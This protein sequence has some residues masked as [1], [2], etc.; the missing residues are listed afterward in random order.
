MHIVHLITSLKIGG[1]ETALYRLL[2]HAEMREHS[3]TILYLYDGPLRDSIEKLGYK[4]KKLSGFFC[5]YDPTLFLTTYFFIR[6]LKPDLVHT[7][8]WS[9]NILGRFVG[10]FL[11]LPV[12]SD[13]HGR[14][15]SEGALRIISEKLTGRFSGALVAVG[16][17]VAR[18]YASLCKKEPF[19]IQNGID[20]LDCREKASIQSLTKELLFFR[21]CFVIGSVGRLEP[22]KGCDRLLRAFALVLKKMAGRITCTLKLC[23]VGDGSQRLFLENLAVELG[24]KESVFFAG[25]QKNALAWYK[26][27]DCFV[28]S[29][30]S[31][32]LS[33]ALLEALAFGVPVITTHTAPT[34][35]VIV[36]GVHG[37]LVQEMTDHALAHALSI[38][39]T[40]DHDA[41]TLMK[42][43]CRERALAYDFSKT[44]Q[45]YLSLYKK[46]IKKNI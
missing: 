26:L 7:A 43:A 46:I 35:D 33:L 3:H 34:H 30:F 29:S 1:A 17:D 14:L 39:L 4:T 2:A 24:I 32:G 36:H 16:Y 28:L 45:G 41:R 44:A 42:K 21:D 38:F 10:L 22:I 23:L 6:S 19:V 9:A 8:L 11:R 27:F 5:R 40:I 13:L 15:S 20:V 37:F 12:I 25:E 31:E 18:D